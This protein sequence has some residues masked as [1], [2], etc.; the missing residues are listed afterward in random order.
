[1]N[2]FYIFVVISFLLCNIITTELVE[3][4]NVCYTCFYSCENG[5]YGLIE[6]HTYQ[7]SDF[8]KDIL[9]YISCNNSDKCNITT[10]TWFVTN[11]TC[12]DIYDRRYIAEYRCPQGDSYKKDITKNSTFSMTELTENGYCNAAIT[13]ISRPLDFCNYYKISKNKNKPP[14]CKCETA[15]IKISIKTN[16]TI[17]ND[18]SLFVA[19]HSKEDV[20]NMINNEKYEHYIKPR[21]N[22]FYI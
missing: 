21:I 4:N 14:L 20:L 9:D 6:H 5:T 18:L 15:D 22:N 8:E 17:C 12:N 11:S 2:K 7:Y 19:Q 3:N 1:M 16:E 10:I 13:I